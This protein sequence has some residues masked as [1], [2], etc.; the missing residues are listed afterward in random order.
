[1]IMK[2]D[3]KQ[4]QKFRVYCSTNIQDS[5]NKNLVAQLV[6][7]EKPLILEGVASTNSVD[8]DGD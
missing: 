7:D 5:V 3:I 1:M 8:L 4:K 2:K 6:E